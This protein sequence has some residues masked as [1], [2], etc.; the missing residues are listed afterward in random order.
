MK[1]I[2]RDIKGYEG[3]YQVSNIGRVK[4]LERIITN[5]LGSYTR[6]EKILVP[7]KT[8]KGYY[9]IH[10]HKN[11]VCK[12]S[13][14]HR[15]VAEAFIPNPL[16]KSQVNHIDGNKINNNVENLEWA[17]QEENMQHA[18]KTGL[19]AQT[20]EVREKIS[21]SRKGK[22]KGE[23][24]YWYGKH[25]TEEAKKKMSEYRKGRYLGSN[26]PNSKKVICITTGEIFGSS[27]EAAEKYN[28]NMR[29]ICKCCRGELKT[30]KKLK[31]KYVKE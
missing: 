10:L 31:W 21:E 27:R 2:W 1:E 29:S 15:L 30:Y 22:Y 20:K 12:T 18:Y 25:Q 26:S 11:G 8:K 17:T 9:Q 24:A 23:K 5:T 16:N 19:K 14:I 4:S 3:L 6:A 13:K 7:L 28:I